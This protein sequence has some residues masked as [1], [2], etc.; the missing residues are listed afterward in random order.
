MNNGNATYK[1]KQSNIPNLDLVN[2]RVPA[3][4][5]CSL[6][7]DEDDPV[8]ISVHVVSFPVVQKDRVE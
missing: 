4:A 3:R 8:A 5:L 7:L 6:E 2:F 1:A